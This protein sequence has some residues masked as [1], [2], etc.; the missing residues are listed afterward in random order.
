MGNYG[1]GMVCLMVMLCFAVPS[2]A[3]VYTVGDSAGWTLGVDYTTWA[4]GKTFNVGD[5]LGNSSPPL[6]LIINVLIGVICIDYNYILVSLSF[7]TFSF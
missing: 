5:S 4:S 1:A 3:T 7:L 6:F 2:L